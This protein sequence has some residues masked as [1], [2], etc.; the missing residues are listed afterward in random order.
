MLFEAK[1]HHAARVLLLGGI[2]CLVLLHSSILP[3]DLSKALS[4]C[5]A[6]KLSDMLLNLLSSLHSEL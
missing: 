2:F 5:T 4:S 6:A 1:C 3:L